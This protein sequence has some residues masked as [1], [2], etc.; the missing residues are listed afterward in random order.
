METK[1]ENLRKSKE[2][3]K[4]EFA[5][6]KKAGKL[7]LSTLQNLL[8]HCNIIPEIIE[9]YLRILEKEDKNSF[10]EELLFYYPILSSNSCKSFGVEKKISEKERFF[11]LVKNLTSIGPKKI[12]KGLKN[13][14]NKE[15]SNYDEIKKLIPLEE[16]EL[17]G[18]KYSRWFNIYNSSIDY[19]NEDN[20]EF[21]FYHLSNSLI[22]EFFRGQICFPKR[23]IL[24]NNIINLFKDVYEKKKKENKFNQ[25]FEFLCFAL[26]NCEQ[27]KED[28][29]GNLH[30]FIKA[31]ENEISFN[32]MN[33]DEI[34]LFLTK[35]NYKFEIDEKKITINHQNKTFI[36]DDYNR[37]NI[38]EN[39]INLIIGKGFRYN[40]I[41]EENIKFSEL[42][43]NANFLNG[44][45]VEI[46]KKY[47]HSAIVHSS[48]EKLFKIEKEEN[49]E[50]FEILS[51]KI[52]NYIIIFPYN[53]FLDTERTF[54]NP[55]KIIIDP[56]KD[57]YSLDIN[58]I[59]NNTELFILLKD[60]CNIV[61]RK[62]AFGHEIHHLTTALLY[63]LYIKE[64]SRLNTLT[65]EITTDGE[66]NILTDSEPKDLKKDSNIQNEAGNLF[67]ILCYGK[68]QKQFTLKQLLFI[69]DE[70][71][72]NLDYKLF[73]E[74][75]ISFT[76]KTLTEI[77]D[78]FPKD[79]ILSECVQKIKE[80][81]DQ[82]DSIQLES[83]GN[84][85]IVKKDD[86]D[87]PHDAYTFLNDDNSALVIELN[88]YDNHLIMKKRPKK[89]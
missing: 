18:N 62:F 9:S 39:V 32:Y 57:K 88:R 22:S 26:T 34:K 28:S 1:N 60:F 52:E 65:K 40:Y 72:D 27:E 49:R 36:I 7:E 4:L 2:E 79:Q 76:Q 84:K 64:D 80:N 86:N 23:K 44:L 83:L 47:S 10:V 35:K 38:N 21:L 56:F 5:E 78:Q 81:L 82:D 30:P 69:A 15:I 66:V 16:K 19:K 3:V 77:L 20:E 70:N 6:Y 12:I 89:P 24:I 87:G 53:C 48:I 74:K 43:N 68:I 46:I 61:Y 71:N 59:N 13:L 75:Y 25:H 63:F 45:F 58:H 54:K 8:S 14:L 37:Y 29:F 17:E 42:I 31:I 85:I 50:L 73:K 55:M 11:E 67:E 51:N 41:L 33:L